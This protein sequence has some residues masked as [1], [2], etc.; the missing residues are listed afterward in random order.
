MDVGGIY[1]KRERK[2]IKVRI[3]EKKKERRH[4]LLYLS[5]VHLKIKKKGFASFSCALC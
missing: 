1:K 3:T 2:V 4:P 5:V